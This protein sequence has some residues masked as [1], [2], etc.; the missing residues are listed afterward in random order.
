[1]RSTSLFLCIITLCFLILVPACDKKDDN[2]VSAPGTASGNFSFNTTSGDFSASGVF[3][4]QATSGSGAGWMDETTLMAYSIASQTS[5]SVAIMMFDT[6]Q[7]GTKAF[8]YPA[9]FGWSLNANPGDQ[10]DIQ[11]KTCA[12]TSGSVVVTAHGGGTTTG[13]FSGAGVFSQSQT[14]VTF[15]NGAFT[16]NAGTGSVQPAL[17]EAVRRVARELVEKMKQ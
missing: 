13:T 6:V 17:P 16:I 10:A 14:A 1:M 11:A 7:V 4:M 15:S 8:P 5:V 12:A 9:G 2:P 3:N